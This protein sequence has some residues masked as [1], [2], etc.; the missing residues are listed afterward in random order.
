MA[1]DGGAADLVGR[2]EDDG[3]ERR[4]RLVAGSRPAVDRLAAVFRQ[5]AAGPGEVDLVAATGARLDGVDAVVLASV[6]T[7]ASAR[8][9]PARR[10]ARSLRWF[11][12]ADDWASCAELVE[13]LAAAGRGHQY[14]TDVPGTVVVE[15][16]YGEDRPPAPSG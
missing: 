7:R 9:R 15:V 11:A 13:V 5:L 1:C 2:L 10:G 3:G 14:L 12:A 4:L 16:S 8:V 6:E